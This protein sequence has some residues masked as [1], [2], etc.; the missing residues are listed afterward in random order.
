MKMPMVQPNVLGQVNLNAYGDK[1]DAPMYSKG[2]TETCEQ[3]RKQ[4]T[5]VLRQARRFGFNPSSRRL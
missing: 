2:L 1:L 3:K 4:Y 5:V